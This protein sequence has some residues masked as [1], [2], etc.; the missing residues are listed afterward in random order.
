MF[1]TY[2]VKN[3]GVYSQKRHI[4][5]NELFYVSMTTI[6]IQSYVE[7]RQSIPVLYSLHS[8]IRGCCYKYEE[9]YKEPLSLQLSS[10]Q[11]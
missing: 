10:R 5:K 11:P 2:G 7:P 9:K 1:K 6:R 3:R 8:Q 4:Y